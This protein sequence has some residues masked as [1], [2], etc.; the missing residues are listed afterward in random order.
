MTSFLEE[1]RN[2]NIF[3]KKC[4]YD[5][6]N[7]LENFIK[8][9]NI[10]INFDDGYFLE[11][12]CLR[13]DINLLNM[14]LRN[15]ANIH[16]NNECVLRSVAHEGCENVLSFLLYNCEVNYNILCDTTAST[17]K[18]STKNILNNFNISKTIK[19]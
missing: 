8:K 10:D 2:Y 17:N 7:E 9:N 14:V 12:I 15:N 18:I 1:T 16:I 3:E 13:D 6:E 5:N 19:C 11:I 4:L